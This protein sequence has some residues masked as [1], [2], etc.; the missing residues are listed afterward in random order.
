MLRSLDCI[1]WEWFGCPDAYKGQN[2]KRD[3]GSNPFILLKVVASQDLWILMSTW[4]AFGGNTRDLGSFWEEM[5]EITNLHQSQRRK[6][7]TDPGDGVTTTCDDVKKSKR[8]R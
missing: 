6:G 1:D 3:H 5:D 4:M 2:V 7:H 8:R